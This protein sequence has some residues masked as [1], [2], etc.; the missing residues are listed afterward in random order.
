[1]L[2]FPDDF[3]P[4]CMSFADIISIRCFIINL[5]LSV[6]G[7][8][9]VHFLT[10]PVLLGPQDIVGH[11]EM[12]RVSSKDRFLA[13][14]VTVDF[15]GQLL[16][17]FGMGLLVLALTWAGSYYPWSTAEVLAPLV[18]GAVLLVTFLLY[19]Y[20]LLPGHFLAEKFPVQQAMISLKLIWTRNAGL[21][22]YIN[23]ITGMGKHLVT[24]AVRS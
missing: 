23:L 12:T 8:V 13:R 2:E 15:G 17:L 22:M 21:L 10:R 9:V 1:M 11:G 19:E 7:L 20:L 24:K 16:F 18:I 5:P 4:C 6:A 14:L 3:H